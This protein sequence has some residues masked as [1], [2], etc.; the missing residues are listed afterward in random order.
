M[1]RHIS[2]VFLLLGLAGGFSQESIGTNQLKI[3]WAVPPDH[4]PSSIWIYKF[5]PQT[6]ARVVVSNLLTISSFEMKDKMELSPEEAAVDKNALCF[7][8]K[9]GTKHLSIVP[10][11]GYILYDDPSAEIK[12][13]EMP[14]G[15]PRDMEETYQLG[16]DY[17]Q[18][19]G[20][21]RSQ[22]VTED[23]SSRLRAEK[24]MG[25]ASWQDNA[26]GT[27]VEVIYMRGVY[28]R[29]QINGAHLADDGIDLQFGNHGKIFR[30]EVTW[31]GW[32]P[33]E[34]HPTLS[35]NQLIEEL[36][37]GK[38]KWLPFAPQPA[39]NKK[40]VIHDAYLLYKEL[41][42]REDKLDWQKPI[43]PVIRLETHI[44]T[45]TTNIP[46]VF[47]CPIYDNKEP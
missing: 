23:G 14:I 45:G 33:Y 21:D 34:L 41:P 31:R 37:S 20:I 17:L 16:L 32:E 38:G 4:V 28:F 5:V 9:D 7:T 29:R 43:N 24:T 39:N 26:H 18:K 36:R 2:F 15:V 42:T 30:L 46:A 3:V 22:L 44:N 35:T 13:H 8:N 12:G 27:N 10:A 40:I 6:F 11:W 25:T 19:L 47:E 1:K